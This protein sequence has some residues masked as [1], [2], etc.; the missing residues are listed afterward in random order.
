MKEIFMSRRESGD[1][2][3]DEIALVMEIVYM[4]SVCVI[5]GINSIFIGGDSCTV[6]KRV[7][8]NDDNRGITYD[9]WKNKLEKDKQWRSEFNRGQINKEIKIEVV[10]EVILQKPKLSK[11]RMKSKDGFSML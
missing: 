1:F 5:E 4:R 3:V 11:I 2:S 8:N 7:N 6:E 10:E 9:M